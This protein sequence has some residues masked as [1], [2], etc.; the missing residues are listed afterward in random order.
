MRHDG[1]IFWVLLMLGIWCHVIDDYV[2]QAPCLG[3]LKQRDWWRK[4]IGTDFHRSGYS[5]D[6]VMALMMHAA[7][8]SCSILLPMLWWT[9]HNGL[10][11][12]SSFFWTAFCVNT[13][14]HAFT[15]NMKA[16]ELSINLI[17]DQAVHLAQITLTTA[18]YVWRNVL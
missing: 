16:N 12:D 15:D 9:V 1:D 2:L 13:L 18:I 14:V 6:Y 11:I 10:Q 7:S 17:T 3:N 8:W 5:H 4:L